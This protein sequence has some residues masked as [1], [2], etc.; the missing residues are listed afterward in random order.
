MDSVSNVSVNE[1]G[2]F[3]DKEE[4]FSN[5]KS[6]KH[7]SHSETD[8]EV[9]NDEDNQLLELGYKPVFKREFST[10]A[11]FSFAFSISG[12]FATVV[13]TYSYPLISGGAPSAVWCWLIAGAGCMCIALSVAELVSAYPTSG[14]LYFT[15]KDLVPARSMPVVAWVVGWLNLLG[16]AAGVSST[17]WS[18]AQLLLAAVSISTDLKYIPTNQHIVGVMAA[19]IV[20][21]GLVNSLSTRWL[22]RITRFYA[23]FHL[24]VLVVCMI[25]LLAKCPKFNTGKYVFTDVQASSGWHPIGF[26][27]LFG[28]LSV[29]WCMTDYDAT[30]HI[31]EEIENA[32]VRAPNA[33]ALALS[34]TYVLGWVFNIVLAFTMGTDLDSLINSELGQPVAQIFYNVLGKKGSMAFT[35]LSFIIINFTGITAMQ[36]NART[37][38]AFSRDQALPF[39]RYWYK[40]NKTTTTPVI[41]V[42]LNVVFCIALNLI[43]LGSIEAIEAIFSVCAI[44]LDWSYVIPIACKLIFG[45]RLNYKPGPWNLGWAS[46]FVNAYAVCWTAFVSVIFLMPTVR[47][48]TPQ[49]MNYAVV[50]LAGVLLF[51][52]VY[53]WSGARKSYIGPRINVDMESE[54]P[55]KTE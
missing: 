12:L 46:H 47:P 2:K 34:I 35:I 38:W 25:C 41:A 42:W 22:D 4:G 30:A 37:I 7:V 28:F 20:F 19:V 53:W 11:T 51:S 33:I 27:F 8:F 32:A 1:Q 13:T 29:A 48:V 10:W 44:A 36:A 39:S 6:L 50:V 54:D 18:C 49:N 24:I 52:L 17:D 40:I 45:K 3:N 5:L 31:A 43:G 15:C 23:T 55:F 21:H 26:S 14:G 9:S 16:Q